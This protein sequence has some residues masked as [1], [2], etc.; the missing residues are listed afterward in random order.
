M[1]HH[2]QFGILLE[3]AA[4]QLAVQPEE[5][6][7]GFGSGRSQPRRVGDQRQFA[8]HG[9]GAGIADCDALAVALTVEDD[10]PTHDDIARIGRRS[11]LIQIFAG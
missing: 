3:D 1:Q 11:F 9:A 4:E 10:A 6:G 5:V 8:E 7:V 2:R